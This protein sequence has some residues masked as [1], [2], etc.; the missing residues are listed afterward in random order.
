[1]VLYKDPGD[2]IEARTKYLT[3]WENTCGAAGG[4]TVMFVLSSVTV[5][6]K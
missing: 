6:Q 5:V 2:L 4:Q 1:M 3:A